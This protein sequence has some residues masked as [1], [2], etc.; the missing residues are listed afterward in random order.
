MK[1]SKNMKME[2]VKF[3]M[4]L[5]GKG[6]R[7]L[8][9][10]WLAW[11]RLLRSVWQIWK[12]ILPVSRQTEPLSEERELAMKVFGKEMSLADYETEGRLIYRL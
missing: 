8:T 3:S 7:H 4:N 11:M 2:N 6:H 12:D 10:I 5:R 9:R 1:S